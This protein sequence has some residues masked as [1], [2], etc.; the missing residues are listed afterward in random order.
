VKEY[1]TRFHNNVKHLNF[2]LCKVVNAHVINFN[3]KQYK[4]LNKSDNCVC[5]VFVVCVCV[6]VRTCQ[7]RNIT[8][9]H[10]NIELS[11]TTR[12]YNRQWRKALKLGGFVVIMSELTQ[13]IASRY[14]N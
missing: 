9:A 12:I 4:K 10:L 5:S 8:C 1:A 2:Y 6:C 11:C 13:I 7:S 14:G 3:Y